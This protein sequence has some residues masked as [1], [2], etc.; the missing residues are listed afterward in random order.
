MKVPIWARIMQFRAR[1]ILKN[2]K[3]VHLVQNVS[4]FDSPINLSVMYFD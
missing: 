2:S 4:D 1:N 3:I